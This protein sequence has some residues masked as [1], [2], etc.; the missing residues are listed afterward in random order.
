MQ[1]ELKGAQADLEAAIGRREEL[2]QRLENLESRLT[3]TPEVEREYQNLTRGYQQLVQQYADIQGKQRE[4]EIAVNLERENKGQ[5]FRMLRPPVLPTFPSQ[6]NRIAIL[7]LGLALALAAGA[8]GMAIAE[9]SD[10]TIRAPRDVVQFLEIPPLVMIPYIDND[11]DVR[12]RRWKRLGLAV[13][14]SAWAGITVF[15]IMNPAG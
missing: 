15:L 7:L 2:N 11:V 12:S 10:T 9:V 6:P 8:G 13:F 1:V 4:A 3:A 5:R 14:A